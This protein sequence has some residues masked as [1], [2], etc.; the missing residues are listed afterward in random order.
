MTTSEAIGQ[1]NMVFAHIIVLS[2]D[3]PYG[4]LSLTLLK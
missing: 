3:V 1:V 4:L 2:N